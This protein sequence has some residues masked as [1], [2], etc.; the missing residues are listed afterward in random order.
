MTKRLTILEFKEEALALARQYT[1]DNNGTGGQNLVI[2]L[3]L[4]AQ[5]VL[6]QHNISFHNSLPYFDNNAHVQALVR[7]EEWLEF[8]EQQMELQEPLITELVFCLRPYLSY[9]LWAAE[10]ITQAVDRIRP[11]ILCS[12]PG[13]IPAC[14]LNWKM[15]LQ[16]RPL[17]F[18]MEQVAA[19]EGLTYETFPAPIT[20]ETASPPHFLEDGLNASRRHPVF[21]SRLLA[22]LAARFCRG[23]KI[24]LMGSES[25]G[26][27]E[28]ALQ[29]S[30]EIPGLSY[31]SLDIDPVPRLSRR[32]AGLLLS[33]IK[34]RWTRG[35]KQRIIK[36]PMFGF[37]PDDADLPAKTRSIRAALDRLA[38]ALEGPQR[39]RFEYLGLDLGP[40]IARKLRTGICHYLEILVQTQARLCTMLQ[41]LNPALVFSAY[42]TSIYTYLGHIAGQM[43]IPTAIVTH[44]THIPPKNK[45]EEIEHR[46]LSQNLMLSEAY[47]YSIAQTPWAQK[48]LEYFGAA[49]RMLK[50][51]P[52][53][54]A[55]TDPLKNQRLRSQLNIS[56]QTAVIVYA[57]SQK[58]RSSLR[59]HIYETEDEY[60][61]SM[62]DL[63][64]A[65][66]RLENVHLVLKLHPS[67]EFTEADIR[68]VLPPCERLSVLHREPFA[69]VLSM[70]DILVSFSSTAIEDAL[71]NR[72]P[73][74]LLD[75]WRRYDHFDVFDCG[76]IPADQ[77]PKS[78][79]YYVSRPG[80]LAR[81]L[82]YLLENKE[83]I[84]GGDNLFEEH[85]Y[86]PGQV[87]SLASRF[88]LIMEHKIPGKT[89]ETDDR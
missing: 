67:T 89:G 66:N 9:L 47:R 32:L 29:V 46:R 44:G 73:V 13:T 3:S 18:L 68:S 54:L 36:M 11:G 49:R 88:K 58:K 83:T 30:S 7:S 34:S 10:I 43:D 41:A 14:D 75:R 65:V 64:E 77:W 86:S 69:D 5:L 31:M 63:V 33:F 52:L 48:H 53:I 27:K 80:P 20:G 37:L 19:R 87:Y 39:T 4:P 22:G 17:G 35:G 38:D 12:A 61:A 74:V 45:P 15:D 42:S 82:E 1:G 50:T 71:A 28:A 57:I 16:D 84:R 76:D 62:G 25:Y 79:I 23:K 8:I 70:A 24:L 78:A 51:G 2:A 21:L 56:P 85:V 6:K 59:F 60:L 40:L 72:I 55:K 26:V 81:V